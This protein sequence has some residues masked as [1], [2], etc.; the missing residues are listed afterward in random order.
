MK[1]LLLI[2]KRDLNSFPKT[3]RYEKNYLIFI[4]DGFGKYL[5]VKLELNF[6]SQYF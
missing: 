3:Q 6:K 1:I 4:C 5:L 2:Q